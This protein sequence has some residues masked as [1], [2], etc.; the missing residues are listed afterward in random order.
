MAGSHEGMIFLTLMVQGGEQM[1]QHCWGWWSGGARPLRQRQA[2]AMQGNANRPCRLAAL[3]HVPSD[4]RSAPGAAE[5]KT[6]FG[7]DR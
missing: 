5:K 1:V 6:F 3:A 2:W 4:S 7:V